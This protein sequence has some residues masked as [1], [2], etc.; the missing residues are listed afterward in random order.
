MAKL[1]AAS[2]GVETSAVGKSLD[3]GTANDAVIGF[4]I[5]NY[6]HEAFK[7]SHCDAILSDAI[8][9]SCCSLDD[10]CDR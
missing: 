8:A 9:L 5:E 2:L 1:A 7:T 4:D 6:D 3:D 10:L